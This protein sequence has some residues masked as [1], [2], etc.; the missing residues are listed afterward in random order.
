LTIQ[1]IIKGFVH[2]VEARAIDAFW[3]SRK[4]SKLMSH[5]E[6]IGQTLLALYAKGVLSDRDSGLILRELFSGIGFVDVAIGL[7]GTLH[8]I[9]MK[10]IRSTLIGA[11]Q[12]ETYM[13]TENRARGWLVYFDARHPSR[14]DAIP[15]SMMTPAGV[16]TVVAI[17]INPLAPS[18]T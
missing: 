15:P 16:V 14:R 1:S 6:K 7:G 11:S 5:A 2:A 13:R 4:K 10:V 17:D 18:K 3:Q 12:L 9:E 8:L